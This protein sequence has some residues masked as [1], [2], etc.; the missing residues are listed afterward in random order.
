MSYP[1]ERKLV[2][3][4]SSNALFNLEIE[5]EIFNKEGLEPYRKFQ[6]S[7]K[8]KILDKG[9]AFPFIRRFLNINAVYK[10]EQPVEVVLLSRN[11][12]E[13]GI[14]IFNSIKK[15]NLNISRAVFTSGKSPFEYIPAYNVSLFLSTNDIDVSNAILSGFAAGK[16]LR[17][18]VTDDENDKELRVAFDFDG[19][20][21]D[22]Q[23][24]KIYQESKVLEL[25]HEYE[26]KNINKPHNP[27]PLAGFF[28]KLSFFQK[29]ESKKENDD[30]GYRKILRTAII[31]ARNAP[32]HERT[33]N[34]LSQWGVTVDE[35]FLMGGIDKKRVLDILKPHIYFDDQLI[36]LNAELSK[37][38][39]VHIP[40][41]ISNK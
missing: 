8:N 17:T 37:I 36:H 3:G 2:V 9:L 31:T 33:V 32:S 41:G 30:P 38:P 24:E 21:A 13:T 18:E 40:F 7:N 5:D 39:L 12:P 6:I 1:I 19:V 16:F 29:L 10:Q 20:I 26:T 35:L 14:R 11:S 15:H 27:G 23:S 28:K 25:F 4:I 34:T 22:D